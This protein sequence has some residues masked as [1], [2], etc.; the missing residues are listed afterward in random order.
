MFRI[1]GVTP[2]LVNQIKKIGRNCLVA[3]ISR[4]TYAIGPLN[5][6]GLGKKNG[7]HKNR[8]ANVLQ[9]RSV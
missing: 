3:V 6:F 2:D 9:D 1:N 4:D 8:P 5:V 7:T